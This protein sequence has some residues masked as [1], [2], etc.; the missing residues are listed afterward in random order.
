MV[1]DSTSAWRTPPANA[2]ARPNAIVNLTLTAQRPPSR[3]PFRSRAAWT[4]QSLLARDVARGSAFHSRQSCPGRRVSLRP[5]EPAMKHPATRE[6]YEYWDKQRGRRGGA[7][8]RRHG[9]GPDPP[10]DRRHVRGRLRPGPSRFPLRVAGTRIC[11]MVG[12]D[13]KGEDF[14]D[15]FARASRRQVEDFLFFA[16]EESLATVAG[17]TAF[18]DKPLAGPSRT[19]AA[20][21]GAVGALSPKRHR[22]AGGAG[23]AGRARALQPC[24]I[25]R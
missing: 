11:A 2:A 9:A 3:R 20:A 5:S 15:L 4:L 25:S 10:S 1:F 6:L 17:V 24:A 7:R 16:T 23:G 18:T 22:L 19:A 8:A 14:L 13:V 21:L 12:R